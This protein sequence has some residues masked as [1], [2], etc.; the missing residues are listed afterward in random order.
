MLFFILLVG[1]LSLGA[2]SY[3]LSDKYPITAYC[4]GC[5][6]VMM[7]LLYLGNLML[8]GF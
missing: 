8:K 6:N 2:V 7:G 3:L 4:L 1:M 5:C